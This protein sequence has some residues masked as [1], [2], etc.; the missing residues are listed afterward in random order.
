MPF[1][2]SINF[3]HRPL[4]SRLR[5]V[6]ANLELMPLRANESKNAKAGIWQTQKAEQLFGPG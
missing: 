1:H 4:T 2:H 6:I 3:H 5:N